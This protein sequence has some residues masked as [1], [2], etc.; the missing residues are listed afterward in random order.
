MNCLLN[1]FSRFQLWKLNSFHH[2]YFYR[3]RVT[4]KQFLQNLEQF[5][6]NE[7]VWVWVFM[8]VMLRFN[9]GK[10]KF[11]YNYGRHMALRIIIPIILLL[12]QQSWSFITKPDPKYNIII[13]EHSL[14]ITKK[15]THSNLKTVWQFM[16]L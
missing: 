3:M 16:I 13:V 5:Q 15:I 14:L 12:K 7:L 4:L 1:S 2:I 9:L 10:W 11:P 8:H 6:H